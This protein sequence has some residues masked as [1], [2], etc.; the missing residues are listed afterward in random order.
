MITD[1]EILR[2]GVDTEIELLQSR[3]NYLE[4][5]L[6]ANSQN[7]LASTSAKIELIQSA[8]SNKIKFRKIFPTALAFAIIAMLLLGLVEVVMFAFISSISIN[9]SLI[10]IISCGVICGGGAY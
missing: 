8:V 4:N 6:A 10:S 2:E 3:I 1:K 7:S 9:I 5:Q